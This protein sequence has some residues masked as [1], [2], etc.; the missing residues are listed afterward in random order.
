M[1]LGLGLIIDPRSFL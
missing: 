1:F